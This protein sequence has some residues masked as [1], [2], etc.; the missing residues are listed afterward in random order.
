MSL[1]VIVSNK[2][3]LEALYG[4]NFNDVSAALDKLIEA[5]EKKGFKT[6]IVYLDDNDEMENLMAPPVTDPTDQR[7]NKT[8]IDA[9]YNSLIPDYLMILGSQDIIPHQHLKNPVIG[10]EDQD[11]PSDLPYASDNKYS[12]T[13]LLF[14]NPT[15]VVGRLPGITGDSDPAALIKAIETSINLKMMTKDKYSQYIAVS[16]EVWQGSTTQSTTNIFGNSNSLYLSPPS[17]PDWTEPQI[18]ALTHFVNCHGSSH[19]PNWYGQKGFEYP[20]SVEAPRIFEKLTDGTIAAAECCYGAQLYDPGS[21]GGQEGLCNS[22]LQ[23]KACAFCGSTNIAYGPLNGQGEAD[24]I[25]QY[26]II[27]LLNGSSAGRAMLEARQKFI[28]ECGTL[29][30]VN[31]K[32]IAQ[33]ILL[34]DPSCHP[35][36]AQLPILEMLEDFIPWSIISSN[37]R[38]ERRQKLVAAGKSL[39]SSVGVARLAKKVEPKKSV[40]ET[41][42]N[43]VKKIGLVDIKIDIFQ[44]TGGA[45]HKKA[46]AVPAPQERIH[47]VY[48]KQHIKESHIPATAI[49]LVKEQYGHVVSARTVYRK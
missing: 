48:G 43:I 44:V 33:F 7:Q 6:Q 22:Y 40:T 20:K 26:F 30:P 12:K 47:M 46:M 1:K 13:I 3:A 23:S 25:T 38:L 28:R 21:V 18:S 2:G 17:G 27:N 24:L 37:Q 39:P 34:A 4:D 32:T 31:Q 15:R 10:D 8:A 42:D 49:L 19:D 14:I 36:F 5:D 11:V 9:I 16:A 35:V 41:I 29:D 45:F